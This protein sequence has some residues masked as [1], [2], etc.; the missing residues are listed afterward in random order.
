MPISF[1][2]ANAVSNFILS[3]D[4]YMQ[5]IYRMDIESGS[6]SAIPNQNIFNPVAI[7]FDPTSRQVFYSDV[8]LSQIRKTNI[9]GTGM[10]VIKQLN[11]GEK[12]F[13]M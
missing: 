12:C 1:V 4:G 6:Y 2:D 7:A 9:D 10:T 13:I 8:K 11:Y 3:A 5:E